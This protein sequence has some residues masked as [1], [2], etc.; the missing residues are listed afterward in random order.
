M[1]RIW[2][3]L[4]AAALLLTLAACGG[5]SADETA[6]AATPEEKLAAAQALA[7]DNASVDEL[8]EAIGE[9]EN[10]NYVSSCLGDGEDGQLQYEGFTVYTYRDP[11]GAE[12][13]Q[14]VLETS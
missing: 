12:A 2:I 5:K 3:T 8:Y 9:P 6:A 11:D 10:S 4:A 1:K 14:D 7:E 13:V